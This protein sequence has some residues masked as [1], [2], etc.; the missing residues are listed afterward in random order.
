MQIGT[1][2]TVVAGVIALAGI[3]LMPA[4]KAATQDDIANFYRGKQIT[5]AVGSQPGS[6]YDLY[7]R[8]T[9][10]HLAKKLPGNP[11]VVAQNMPG[12]EGRV[13]ANWLYNIAPQ[14]G[15]AIATFNQSTPL[16][17]RARG[18]ESNST[19][20]SSTGSATPSSIPT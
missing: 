13:V 14:D 17:R 15:T 10:R 18:R 4:A 19:S 7:A 8:T 6:N 5:L 20:P 9:A 12:A 3:A 1:A 2:T 16:T 11:T